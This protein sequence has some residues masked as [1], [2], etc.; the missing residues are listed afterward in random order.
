MTIFPIVIVARV[1]ARRQQR[2]PTNVVAHV[3]SRRRRG[4][5]LMQIL[6]RSRILRRHRKH[7][8]VQKSTLR[9]QE[10]LAGSTRWW[11]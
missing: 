6:R 7:R 3:T 8:G 10:R 9:K 5:A 2:V 11:S 1:I 4:K